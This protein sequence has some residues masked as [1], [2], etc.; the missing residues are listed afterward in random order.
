VDQ[1]FKL[2]PSLDP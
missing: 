1:M 2:R